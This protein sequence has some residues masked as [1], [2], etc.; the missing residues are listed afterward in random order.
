[1]TA[2]LLLSTEDSTYMTTIISLSTN[3]SS[4]NKKHDCNDIGIY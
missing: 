2:I 1:M 3:D 4:Y